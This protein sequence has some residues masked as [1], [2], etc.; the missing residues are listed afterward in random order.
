MIKRINVL[1]TL[2][3]TVLL[4]HFTLQAET[5]IDGDG[6]TRIEGEKRGARYAVILPD[7]WN[8]EMVLMF[9]VGDRGPDEL[10][11]FAEPIV[12]LGYGVAF[13]YYSQPLYQINDWMTDAR[14][15]EAMFRHHFTKPERVY[16]FSRGFGNFAMFL[17]LE[18][19]PNRYAGALAQAFGGISVPFHHWLNSVVVFDYFYPGV[20]P[21]DAFLAGLTADEIFIDLLPK[22]LDA[23]FSDPERL[24]LMA[25]VDQLN[26]DVPTDPLTATLYSLAF[27]LGGGP[28]IISSAGGIPVGNADLEYTGDLDPE[29]LDDLNLNVVRYATDRKAVSFVRRYDPRGRIN[30]TPI[31]SLLAPTGG[32][33]PFIDLEHQFYLERLQGTGNEEWLATR[34]I[35]GLEHSLD[36]SVEDVVQAFV[37]LVAWSKGGPKPVD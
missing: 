5:T 23:V 6:F 4:G 9:P 27:G 26:F 15:A 20:L 22:V 29:L 25:K 32:D 16:L 19:T 1:A 28:Q 35:D 31:L 3:L 11:P 13:S 7:D 17:F 2:A 37:D 33:F 14:L 24:G 21:E 30:G 36:H 8:G 18:R 10:D 34:S 12:N